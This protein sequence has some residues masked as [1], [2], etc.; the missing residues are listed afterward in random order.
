MKKKA[1]ARGL[2]VREGRTVGQ[3]YPFAPVG[4]MCAESAADDGR[5]SYTCTREHGHDGPHV[6]HVPDGSAIVMWGRS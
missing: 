2:T 6:A 3:Q 5:A 1:T 4:F